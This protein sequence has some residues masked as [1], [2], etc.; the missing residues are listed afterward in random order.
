ML[1][2]QALDSSLRGVHIGRKG[3][4]NVKADLVWEDLGGSVVSA[5]LVGTA[6]WNFM[7]LDLV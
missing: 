3:I 4:E 1:V 5:R 7:T 2:G 6:R